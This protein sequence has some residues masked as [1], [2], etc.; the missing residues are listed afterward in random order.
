[1]WQKFNGHLFF[2]KFSV[3]FEVSEKFSFWI[4]AQAQS[5]V[6]MTEKWEWVLTYESRPRREQRPFPQESEERP[7]S[8]E[9]FFSAP[10]G[11]RIGI[12]P[13]NAYTNYP[14]WN[15]LFLQSS[16]FTAVVYFPY[17]FLKGCNFCLGR[18]WCDGAN[19]DVW[20]GV[21]WRNLL[22]QVRLKG[23]PLN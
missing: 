13:Q 4:D 1:M 8:S 14:S 12:Q 18:T 11:D 2:L 7:S 9:C 22:T 5:G 21:S 16:S 3:F 19:E 17:N 23:W 20:R 10:V 6:L 15:V